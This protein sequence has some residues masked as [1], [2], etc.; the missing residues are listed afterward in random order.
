MLRNGLFLFVFFGILCC[1]SCQSFGP[2]PDKRI[3]AQLELAAEYASEEEIKSAIE[4]IKARFEKFGAYPDVEKM[5]DNNTIRF[6]FETDAPAERV[7]KYL[8]YSAHLEFYLL[9]SKSEMLNFITEADAYLKEHDSLEYGPIIR[10]ISDNPMSTGSA[11]FGV[12]ASDTASLNAHLRN[13][14]VL[15]FIPP[16]LGPTKFLWGRSSVN[17]SI[18]ELYAAATGSHGRPVIDGSMVTEAG[19]R[20]NPIGIDVV[21][22]QMNAEGSLIWEE[23]TLQ[24]YQNHTQIAIVLDGLVVSAPGV[25]NGPISGGRSEIN[26]DFTEEEAKELANNIAAGP[27]PRITVLQYSVTPLKD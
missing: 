3:D 15:D 8:T 22:L 12:V 7:L 26:G 5:S 11:L 17:D 24:A 25:N 27:I 2:K 1:Y 21:T 19:H 18:F 6:S 14:R 9:H 23:M 13:K 4:A 20:L 16:D 10:M